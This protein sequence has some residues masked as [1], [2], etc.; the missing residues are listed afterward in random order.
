[1]VDR[2]GRMPYR[3]DPSTDVSVRFS[4]SAGVNG[5]GKRGMVMKKNL[6]KKL[7]LHRETLRPLNESLAT[8]QGG[9][10]VEGSFCVCETGVIECHWTGTYLC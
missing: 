8:V 5:S 4:E 7:T 9:A 10:T 6:A 3:R 2:A 1:M